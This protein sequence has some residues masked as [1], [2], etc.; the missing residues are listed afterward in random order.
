M[1]KKESVKT[2]LELF[3]TLKSFDMKELDKIH[4]EECEH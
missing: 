2:P 1:K 4:S 3:G